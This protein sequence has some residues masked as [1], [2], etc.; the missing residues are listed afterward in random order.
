MCKQRELNQPKIVGLK[1]PKNF[2]EHKHG[3]Y[4]GR[5]IAYPETKEVFLEGYGAKN[6]TSIRKVNGRIASL[7]AD[8]YNNNKLAKAVF[9]NYKENG[10]SIPF[11]RKVELFV[12][13]NYQLDNYKYTLDSINTDLSPKFT[14]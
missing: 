11:S 7:L 6:A 8:E 5:L 9:H 1:T 10:E 4:N 3:S 12:F 13:Y 2:F 14:L